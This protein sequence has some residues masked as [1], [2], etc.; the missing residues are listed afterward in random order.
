ML[1]LLPYDP[2][3][4]VD[5]SYFHSVLMASIYRTTPVEFLS[6]MVLR[7]ASGYATQ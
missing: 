1:K 2:N 7:S 6:S 4:R 3:G 5:L